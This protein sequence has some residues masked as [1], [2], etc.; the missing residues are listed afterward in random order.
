MST[1]H[2]EQPHV[3]PSELV[4]LFRRLP[5]PGEVWRASDGLMG[6]VRIEACPVMPLGGTSS[7]IA[8]RLVQFRQAGVAYVA[9]IK[10]FM[11]FIPFTTLGA[12]PWRADSTEKGPRTYYAPRFYCV[13]GPHDERKAQVYAPGSLAERAAQEQA[14]FDLTQ[15]LARISALSGE[16]VEGFEMASKQL[17][18]LGRIARGEQ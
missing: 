9:S 3:P 5:Q 1:T 16:T 8:D 14:L 7:S 2:T 15:R 18:M 13:S 4:P 11:A 12:V 10:E 17:L 6:D